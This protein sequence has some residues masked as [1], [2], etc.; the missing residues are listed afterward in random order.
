[1]ST[2]TWPVNKAEILSEIQSLFA[3]DTWWIYTGEKVKELQ[4]RFAEF[5]ESRFGIAT[6]NGTVPL[7][8]ALKALGIGAGDRVILPAYDF[9]SLPRSVV[10]VSAVPVFVDV[11]PA[12]LSMDCTLVESALQQ[13]VQAVVAVHLCGAVAKMDE[14]QRMCRAQSVTLIE[15]CAQ[16][17]GA[18]YKGRH[19]GS[20]GDVGL[21]SFGGVKL[22]TSGQGGMIVTSNE[23]IADKCHALVGRGFGLDGTLNKHGIIGGNY[24]ISELAATVLI[25]QLRVLAE[26]CRERETMMVQLD[27]CI[28]KIPGLSPLKLHEGTEIRSQFRYSFFVDGATQ[29]NGLRDRLLSLAAGRGVPLKPGYQAVGMDG[30]LFDTFTGDARC[31]VAEAM[32]PKVVSIFHMDILQKGVEYWVEFLEGASRE[33]IRGG[34]P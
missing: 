34:R 10:S 26:L 16:S 6:C 8:I 18:V 22:M 25:P 14:L 19:V 20:W 31:P 5:H 28:A 9:Y 7:E 33:C 32:Q 30:R 12:N 21:F 29:E 4:R 17:T 1:M 15:D 3:S 27:E 2:K 11:D 13:G 23:E 24:Q